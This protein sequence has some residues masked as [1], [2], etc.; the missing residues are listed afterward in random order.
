MDQGQPLVLSDL[1]D[2]EPLRQAQD[3]AQTQKTETINGKNIQVGTVAEFAEKVFGHKL[4]ARE[5]AF[6]VFPGGLLLGV[7]KFRTAA[8]K[9]YRLIWVGK[10]TTWLAAEDTRAHTSKTQALAAG[11]RV[12]AQTGAFFDEGTR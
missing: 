6:P 1:P 11:Y 9:F 7:E 2:P 4:E 8:G 5:G 10:R 3:T 12:A